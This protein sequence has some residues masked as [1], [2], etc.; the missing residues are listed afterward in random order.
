MT[1]LDGD[2]VDRSIVGSVKVDC[3]TAIGGGQ[4][5]LFMKIQDHIIVGR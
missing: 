1:V 2:N 5:P 3:I 4:S